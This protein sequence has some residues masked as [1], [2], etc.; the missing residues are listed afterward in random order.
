MNFIIID[1]SYY[2]F[3][4][5][6]ATK[7]WWGFS[8]KSKKPMLESNEPSSKEPEN[9]LNNEEFVDKFKKT[10]VDSIKTLHKLVGLK[11]NDTSIFMVGKDCPRKNIWRKKLHPEYKECRA[12]NNEIGSAFSMV[13][14]EDLYS[15]GGVS[16]TLY[17]RELEAD[18]CVALTARHIVN[19]YQDANVWII[20]SDMDYLQL[21]SDRIHLIAANGKKL[22]DSKD[23]FNDPKK[24]LFCKIISGDK[25]DNIP[26]VFSR[27]GIK[28]AG[29]YYEDKELFRKKLEETPG[30]N[31]IYKRNQTL[32]D[33]DNIPTE[34]SN[35]FRKECLKL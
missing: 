34:L 14:G 32:I 30:A 33:F 15:S 8:N 21:S 35:R 2:I 24:D 22:T 18:D 19:K 1:G 23:S 16:T 25:S 6:Y 26:G 11:K 31:E 9:I 12:T 20:T 3:Y 7:K 5:Y 13:Y 4:R 27:C 10:F 17:D 28:T 29:K